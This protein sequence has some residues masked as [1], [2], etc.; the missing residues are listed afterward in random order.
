MSYRSIPVYLCTVLSLL[1]FAGHARAACQ[2]ANNYEAEGGLSGWPVRV[3]NSSD[4]TL[5]AAYAAGTCYY[6]KGK[7]GGGTTPA[8]APDNIHVNVIRN[9]VQ[10]HVFK[11]QSVNPPAYYPTTCF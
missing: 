10:C 1:L 11:K 9:G 3:E 5:R 2:L 6:R 7:H 4:A 8:G